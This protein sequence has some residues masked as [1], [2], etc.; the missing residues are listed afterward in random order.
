MMMTSSRTGAIVPLMKLTLEPLARIHLIRGYSDSEILIGEQSVRS[1]CIVSARELITEW[2]PANF[3]EFAPEHLEKILAL[4]P[5][6]ILLGTGPVQRFVSAS[7]RAA[8]AARRVGLETMQ[9]GA[10]CRT[11]N[12]LVQ[13]ERRVA[14]ALFLR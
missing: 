11:Y 1:S 12:V 8:L 10:A 4:D 6:L 3:G 9:L 2:E 14:A 7:L 13:E 5:E